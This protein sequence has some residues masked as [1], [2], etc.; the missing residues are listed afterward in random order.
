VKLGRILICL[1]SVGW[2][3]PA[4]LSGRMFIDHIEQVTI[5]PAEP[6]PSL[7]WSTMALNMASVW[8]A[9]VVVFWSWRATR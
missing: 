7:E 2:L 3:A 4:W 6:F 1:F 8:L 9:A 5:G